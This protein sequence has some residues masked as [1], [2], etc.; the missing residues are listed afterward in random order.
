MIMTN[1]TRFSL[2]LAIAALAACG[3]PAPE[4][5][6]AA[7]AAV[8]TPAANNAVAAEAA[9]A[10][11]PVAAGGAV[12]ADYMVG[13]WSAMNEDCADTLE[14]RKDGSVKTPFGDAKWT[15]AGDQLGVDFG[16]GS[17]QD[18]STIRVLGPDRI[19]I[20]KKSGGKETQK[21]C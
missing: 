8:E 15:L 7:N 2:G 6:N 14:F 3:Q 17:K 18:P 1:Q 12:T 19:E 11:T 5:A 20:T 13:K 10:A 4:A 9:P 16:D 21:R